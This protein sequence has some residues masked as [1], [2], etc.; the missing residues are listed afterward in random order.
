MRKT[1]KFAAL[2]ESAEQRVKLAARLLAAHHIKARVEPWDGM[3]C[4][5]VVADADDAYGRQVIDSA[6]R[7]GIPILALGGSLEPADGV[8]LLPE[9]L[10]A[11]EL[12]RALHR[13]INEYDGKST[14]GESDDVEPAAA[15]TAPDTGPQPLICRL[16]DPT[17][18]GKPMDLVRSGRWVGLRPGRGR[19]YASAH[20]DLNEARD[21]LLGT[22]WT[23]DPGNETRTG[24]ISMSMDAFF[25]VAAQ[26]GRDRLPDF[27]DKK[28][29]LRHWPDLGSAPDQ[30]DA[31]RAA[32]ALLQSFLDVDAL[33][34]RCSIDRASANACMWAF[35]AANLLQP[36]ADTVIRLHAPAK[37][38]RAPRHAIS[39]LRRIG[40]RFGLAAN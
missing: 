32:R 18:V 20:S 27:G 29:K 22:Q 35:A 39:L 25:I 7:R 8:F 2:D 14:A 11:H 23:L 38:P 30:I 5:A 36:E 40:A 37:R 31:L 1:I 24:E 15:D 4:D 16:S 33:A 3:R 12:S 13:S 9:N 6:Q 21:G 34:A 26:E 10:P 28:F 19:V 17:I